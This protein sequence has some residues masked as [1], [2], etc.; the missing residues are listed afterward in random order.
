M[1]TTI[2]IDNNAATIVTDLDTAKR[3]IQKNSSCNSTLKGKQVTLVY[4]L[5]ETN[6]L[7]SLI[8]SYKL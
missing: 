7:T 4:P 6:T 8:K 5:S 1:K 2:T 3:I